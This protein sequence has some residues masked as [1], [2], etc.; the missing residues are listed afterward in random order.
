MIA[1]STRIFDGRKPQDY[2][3]FTKGVGIMFK[4]ATIIMALNADPVKHRALIKSDQFE[5]TTVVTPLFDFDEAARVCKELVEKDGVQWI[6]LCPGFSHEA[7]A[8]VRSAIGGGVA[9]TV[10]RG[11]VQSTM[12]TDQILTK[13]GWLP[14]GH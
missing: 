4:A 12:I 11:D 13:E 3:F 7:V 10:A 14:P 5:Y 8:K 6:S 1:S 2:N 9:L